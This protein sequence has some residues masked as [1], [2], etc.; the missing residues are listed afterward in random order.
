MGDGGHHGHGVRGLLMLPYKEDESTSPGLV[1]VGPVAVPVQADLGP[2]VLVE[3]GGDARHDAD[4]SGPAVLGLDGQ[5]LPPPGGSIAVEGLDHGALVLCI[6]RLSVIAARRVPVGAAV[7]DGDDLRVAIAVKVG[8]K[9]VRVRGQ[10]AAPQD[11]EVG[12]DGGE[13]LPGPLGDRGTMASMGDKLEVAVAVEIAGVELTGIDGEP[14]PQEEVRRACPRTARRRGA[15]DRPRAV[16]R[17]PDPRPRRS[18][19]G[20]PGAEQGSDTGDHSGCLVPHRRLPPWQWSPR[21]RPRAGA[22]QTNHRW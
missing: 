5:C 1:A 8:Q 22:G 14:A 16:V 12:I 11:R 17:A 2:P 13:L 3:V 19:S 4:H 6:R 18:L 15:A 9:G 10:S 20:A 7:D 21:V